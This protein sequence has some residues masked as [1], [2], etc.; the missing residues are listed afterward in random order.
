[1]TEK[2][3]MLAFIVQ[4]R[5]LLAK[6][7]PLPKLRRGWALIRVRLAGIC[8]TDL[9]ILRGYHGFRGTP[10][11]EFVGEVAEV[12]G[13][14]RATKREWLGRRVCAEIN[15]SFSSY[16]FKTGP[17]FCRRTFHTHCAR[18]TVLG[19]VAQDGAFAQSL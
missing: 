15:V 18:R 7:E 9:E 4:D 5:T 17:A 11:H 6:K 19:I 13:V 14:S 12:Q 2:G 16:C 1:M 10:G 8:N 3:G